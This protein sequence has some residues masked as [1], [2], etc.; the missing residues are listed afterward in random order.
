MATI[1]CAEL[2]SDG[3]RYVGECRYTQL[4]VFIVLLVKVHLSIQKAMSATAAFPSWYSGTW[5][6]GI[7]RNHISLTPAYQLQHTIGDDE[8]LV[9]GEEIQPQHLLLLFQE[10]ERQMTVLLLLLWRDMNT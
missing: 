6:R 7:G 2:V 3:L 10:R 5:H 1:S 4:P 8:V 9:I